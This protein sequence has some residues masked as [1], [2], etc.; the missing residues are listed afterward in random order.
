MKK[1]IVQIYEIQT[2]GEA[3]T[4]IELG[5]DH[6]GS[7][8][9]KRDTWKFPE[10]R[11]TMQQVSSAGKRSSL[12][13]LF[14]NQDDICRALDFYRPD[15]IHFCEDLSA[16]GPGGVNCRTI[17]DRQQNI[18][19]RFPEIKVMRS[20]PIAPDRMGDRVPTLEMAGRF[21]SIS[22]YFL[23]DTLLVD[24]GDRQGA[25]Q[26]ESGFIGITGKICDWETARQLVE[27][28]EIP[29][30]LAGGIK[31][32]NVFDAIAHTRP[33]GI[34][35]CTGTNAVDPA[36]NTVRF[37]KDPDLVR[38]LIDEVERAAAAAG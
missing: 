37:K 3:E 30:I 28:T 26:P 15:I 13:P 23:T 21:E 12:I 38:R 32:D 18:K 9:V 33:A 1:M 24:A 16:C 36:G 6:I 10:V 7:V 19:R 29:V 17:F 25:Q 20:I 14:E 5:V 2:P 31:P 35:S 4:M 34:D 11:E 22:D 8:V 27:T